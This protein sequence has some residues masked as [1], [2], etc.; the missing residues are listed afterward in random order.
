MYF[1][2]TSHGKTHGILSRQVVDAVGKSGQSMPLLRDKPGGFV[3][4][5]FRRV[6]FA[7]A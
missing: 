3:S 6:G 7:R 5:T 2:P 4:I 1:F